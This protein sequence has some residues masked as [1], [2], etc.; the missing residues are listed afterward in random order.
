[1]SD[2]LFKLIRDPDIMVAECWIEGE[3]Y[4][5]FKRALSVQEFDRWT[6]LKRELSRIH[7]D[8]DNP[9]I[10]IWALEKK[11]SFSTKS[12]YRFIASGGCLVT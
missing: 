4:V 9:D 12:L 3:W 5:E 7:L 2:D 11:G 6:E 10:V 8:H 1:M